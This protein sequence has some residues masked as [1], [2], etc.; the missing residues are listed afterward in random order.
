M[1]ALD[2][3]SLH[4]ISG[5]PVVINGNTIP[6]GATVYAFYKLDYFA[7][8]AGDLQQALTQ[9]YI[10]CIGTDGSVLSLQDSFESSSRAAAQGTECFP[11]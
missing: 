10:E 4:N 6:V 1:A 2:V 9:G 11:A 7:N 5:S 8:N 3:R